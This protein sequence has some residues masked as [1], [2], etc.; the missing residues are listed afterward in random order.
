MQNHCNHPGPLWYSE[1]IVCLWALWLV[2]FNTAITQLWWHTTESEH[3]Q[4]LTG[5]HCTPGWLNEIA[6]FF[7]F[8]KQMFSKGS[9]IEPLSETAWLATT[10][11]CLLIIWAYSHISYILLQQP[12]GL[13]L[14]N[15]IP[16]NMVRRWSSITA[17]DRSGCICRPHAPI[18]SP[19]LPPLNKNARGSLECWVSV[20]RNGG[21]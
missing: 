17:A 7:F 1:L 3:I 20:F 19:I 9:K 2:I 18:H 10:Q 4:Y 11:N 14:K 12:I 15:L 6:L 8:L 5:S 13:C 16:G 21:S